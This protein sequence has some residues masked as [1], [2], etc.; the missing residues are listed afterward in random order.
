MEKR[1]YLKNESGEF[2]EATDSDYEEAFR[3][4]SDKIV[5]K[6]LAA[7]VQNA[8]EKEKPEF[9]KQLREEESS[10]I[11]KEVEDELKPKIDEAEHR[12]S[13]LQTQLRRKTI[14]AEYGFKPEAE[15]FLGDGTEDE[16]RAKADTLKNSFGAPKV[17]FP[18][19]SNGEPDSE[20]LQKYGLDV[21]I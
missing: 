7:S 18:D 9:I 1:F 16:M 15:E 4:R 6:R 10:K 12:A 14:A 21:K 17:E 2:I 5:S 20:S 19:K 11:R 13:D 3:E 8:L